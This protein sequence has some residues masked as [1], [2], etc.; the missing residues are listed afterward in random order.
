MV[1]IRSGL[2][3][4]VTILVLFIIVLPA[5]GADR[6]VITIAGHDSPAVW[7]AD[8][9]IRCDGFN[10]Q[11]QIN[12]A[13]A[14]KVPAQG[15]T[16]VLLPGNFSVAVVSGQDYCILINRDDVSL[17]FMD[18]AIVKMADNQAAAGLVQVV[19][20][21][22]D[23][24]EGLIKNVTVWG[25]GVIDYNGEDWTSG[26]NGGGAGSVS[27]CL[28]TF[29]QCDNVRIGGGL[30]LKNANG[31]AF[32]MQNTS[33]T[34]G[35]GL[36]CDGLRIIDSGEAWF[37]GATNNVVIT[38][39]YMDNFTQDAIEPTNIVGLRITNN[40]IKNYRGA[41]AVDLFPDGS[42]TELKQV[43]IAGNTIGPCASSA[44]LS[45]HINAGGGASG[46][47][48]D[49][50]LDGLV[51][52]DNTFV[53]TGTQAVGVNVGNW[54]PLSTSSSVSNVLIIGNYFD[55][56]GTDTQSV[57][58]AVAILSACNNVSVIGNVIHSYAGS[59]IL[60][61]SRDA[62]VSNRP[63]TDV[64]IQ[65]NLIFNNNQVNGGFE[66]GITIDVEGTATEPDD[67]VITGNYIFDNQGSPTQ[68]DG[69][70]MDDISTA[71]DIYVYANTF[72]NNINSGLKDA[73]AQNAASG[74]TVNQGQ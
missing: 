47:P 49:G 8:A 58:C 12:D 48:E 30:T 28:M 53:H 64:L 37:G 59:G 33:A 19:S 35:N 24:T 55:G 29:G 34:D 10:D 31:R 13:I 70:N 41:Q 4:I 69:L 42:A 63:P 71:T 43:V 22:D 1:K 7:K 26:G 56:T 39:C 60:I 11:V 40:T 6:G 50:T 68:Q 44:T 25:P 51:I 14:N 21:Q 3:A 67:I 9:D 61:S 66:D 72:R 57:D 18:G 62:T 38:N 36:V 23:S 27:A 2:S 54:D 74:T 16:V 17:I 46:Q 32:G 52:A 45:G 73:N 5:V 20:V 65:G 15:G